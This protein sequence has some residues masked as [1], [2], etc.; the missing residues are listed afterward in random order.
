LI[1]WINAGAGDLPAVFS[2]A[3]LHLRFVEI[4]PFRDGNGRVG[5]ALATWQL[6][7]MGFDTLHIFALDEVLLENRSLYIKALQ[8][9]QTGDHDAGGWIE[10]IAEAVLETLERVQRRVQSLGVR[11]NVPVFLTA[12]QERLLTLLRERGALGIREVSRALRVTSPGAH[13]ALKPLIG[14]GIVQVLGA[15]KTTRYAL[16][17]TNNQ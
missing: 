5:R 16:S 14:H 11:G 2:S 4:H 8:R 15:H 9:A 6:Y 3:L 13:Y 12:R 17:A 7:R 10:F 1:A